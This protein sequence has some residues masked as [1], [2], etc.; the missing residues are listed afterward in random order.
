M[1]R[2]TVAIALTALLLIL[3][4]PAA[5]ARTNNERAC[6]GQNTSYFVSHGTSL[7][8]E[9]ATNGFT[10]PGAML[11]NFHAELPFGCIGKG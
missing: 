10:S 8:Q 7:K 4:T 9:A 6:F 2:I 11:Q 5:S 1:K 3:M